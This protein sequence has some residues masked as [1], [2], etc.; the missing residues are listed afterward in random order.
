MASTHNSFVSSYTSMKTP[1]YPVEDPR[2]VAPLAAPSPRFSLLPLTSAT[3]LR[4]P[5]SIPIRP[6]KCF[7]SGS[8]M[9]YSQTGALPASSEHPVVQGSNG[10]GQ[11]LC[12]SG[13]GNDFNKLE[14]YIL[15]AKEKHT[16]ITTDLTNNGSS[17]LIKEEDNSSVF[18]PSKEESPLSGKQTATI[19]SSNSINKNINS[20]QTESS[21]IKSKWNVSSPSALI[22]AINGGSKCLM[23]H[24]EVLTASLHTTLVRNQPPLTSDCYSPV[25]AEMEA[26]SLSHGNPLLY[27]SVNATA[28]QYINYNKH[29]LEIKQQSPDER[30]RLSNEQLNGTQNMYRYHHHNGQQSQ[31]KETESLIATDL[32]PTACE[33]AKENYLIGKN[34]SYNLPCTTTG[35]LKT[36]EFQTRKNEV[37]QQYS[38][39]NVSIK[40]EENKIPACATNGGNIPHSAISSFDRELNENKLFSYENN[41]FSNMGAIDK[42]HQIVSKEGFLY[43]EGGTPI[44]EDIISLAK[45]AAAN[46]MADV[47]EDIDGQATKRVSH[48]TLAALYHGHMQPGHNSS[49]VNSTITTTTTTTGE[50]GIDKA[51]PFNEYRNTL[52]SELAPFTSPQGYKSLLLDQVVDAE[53]TSE[54]DRD[55]TSV[56]PDLNG[57]E[58]RGRKSRQKDNIISANNEAGDKLR[59]FNQ[60]K[61]SRENHLLIDNYEEVNAE[62]AMEGD[63]DVETSSNSSRSNSPLVDLRKQAQLDGNRSFGKKCR[64][65]QEN[66][67]DLSMK[68]NHHKTPMVIAPLPSSMEKIN[69]LSSSKCITIEPIM[70][71][72]IER[73]DHKDYRCSPPG[74]HVIMPNINNPAAL[75]TTSSSS[76]TTNNRLSSE[77]INTKLGGGQYS[78]DKNGQ[79]N[80]NNVAVINYGKRHNANDRNGKTSNN[81][82]RENGHNLAAVDGVNGGN[83]YSHNKTSGSFAVHTIMCSSNGSSANSIYSAG[84]AT[85]NDKT[86]LVNTTAGQSNNDP[87]TCSGS[88]DKEDSD[89]HI[90]VDQD[91]SDSEEQPGEQDGGSKRPRRMTPGDGV[92][93]DGKQ[94]GGLAEGMRHLTAGDEAPGNPDETES[95]AQHRDSASP[96]DSDEVTNFIHHLYLSYSNEKEYKILTKISFL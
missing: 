92:D 49:D 18:V 15:K 66:P 22:P 54:T 17:I 76:S 43:K 2:L 93:V 34:N 89:L 9:Y 52:S 36:E 51:T 48:S 27:N 53:K 1:K 41:Y 71:P 68:T 42:S 50:Q 31:V 81:G 73:Y 69:E 87:V 44:K 79:V 90:V 10:F 45:D 13:D 85:A 40:V 95:D 24:K 72:Y 78:A 64:I 65:N 96:K 39:T 58:D 60:G 21:I 14:N 91:F 94:E 16:V 77:S 84:L 56:K 67:E 74:L 70:S 75:L 8:Q 6:K 88:G 32:L 55:V 20:D 57:A 59:D 29:M 4:P 80:H 33:R 38:F 28:C 26:P 47:V 86:Q 11:T 7:N 61:A 37:K 3:Y 23:G 30:V 35:V 5:K 83:K 46:G 63:I 82:Q 12:N 62:D 25:T 19:N